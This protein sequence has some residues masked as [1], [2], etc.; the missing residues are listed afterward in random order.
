MDLLLKFFL[1]MN[2]RPTSLLVAPDAH[3]FKLLGDGS[4]GEAAG[5]LEGRP[6]LDVRSRT[7]LTLPLAGP[8]RE[9]IEEARGNVAGALGL[10]AR[11]ILGRLG[12]EVEPI[13]DGTTVVVANALETSHR[14]I[15]LGP[16][17]G[18]VLEAVRNMMEGASPDLA[19]GRHFLLPERALSR[20][21]V[22]AHNG[23]W[24]LLPDSAVLNPD[25]S[26]GIPINSAHYP[27]RRR[28]L[29]DPSR[30][31]GILGQHKFGLDQMQRRRGGLPEGFAPG[32]FLVSDIYLSL[33]QVF[34]VLSG[35]VEGVHHL[36]PVLLDAIRSSGLIVPRHVEL[37]NRT[38]QSIDP[39]TLTVNVSLY[40]AT[41]G[42]RRVAGQLLPSRKAHEEG[43]HIEDV[44]EVDS[45]RLIEA[46]M[47]GLSSESLPGSIFARFLTPGRIAEFTWP[48]SDQEAYLSD[49]LCEELP[50]LLNGAEGVEDRLVDP[51]PYR[52]IMDALSYVGGRLT[53]KNIVAM[54]TL[55]NPDTLKSLAKSGVGTFFIRHLGPKRSF[56]LSRDSFVEL[57]RLSRQGVR[58]FLVNPDGSVRVFHNE[59]WVE[60]KNRERIDNAHTGIVNYGSS[61]AGSFEHLEP[62]FDA[63]FA[64]L[65][66]MP[67]LDM[68]AGVLEIDGNGPAVMQM[69]SSS[70]RKNGIATMG[71]GTDLGAIE[72]DGSRR[73]DAWA[74]FTQDA[75]FIRQDLM[76]RRASFRLIHVGGLG[77]GEELFNTATN[78]KVLNSMPMPVILMDPKAQERGEHFW[79]PTRQQI[80]RFIESGTLDARSEW[81]ARCLHYVSSPA[82]A[83]AVIQ[84]F[85]RDPVAYWNRVGV[86]AEQV[87]HAFA[88]CEAISRESGF[89][90]PPYLAKAVARL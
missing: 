66:Q 15:A 59:T 43:V 20:D 90:I 87:K 60:P 70:A 27:L 56:N 6:F 34:A 86:S 18:P 26:V 9:A 46:L 3:A 78:K 23:D 40:P 30:I 13:Q 65:A 51:E 12:V 53:E 5:V 73:P 49:D 42:L 75:R 79:E 24:H 38:D 36:S 1:P 54:D 14:L 4:L 55:P 63:F 57:S 2:S 84:D 69:A 67:E 58:F 83:L 8:M 76:E 81:A 35:G 37:V 39:R 88:S 10:S 47:D 25:G 7:P 28:V 62:E 89:K 68:G 50:R 52:A 41:E 61:V 16:D 17:S 45:V 74:T 31:K 85:V 19:L 71:I 64:G 72:Q 33:G 80:Q 77:T 22:E 32:D 44:L 21:E 48:S 29:R 82:E 11:S